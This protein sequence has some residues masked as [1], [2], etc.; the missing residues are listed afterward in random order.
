MTKTTTKAKRRL[1]KELDAFQKEIDGFQAEFDAAVAKR[2]AAQQA[3]EDLAVR[4]RS[5]DL[6]R[7]MTAILETVARVLTVTATG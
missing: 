4:F 6:E 1:K 7:R 5:M 3:I 2:A